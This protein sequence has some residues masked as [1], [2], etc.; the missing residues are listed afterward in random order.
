M[1]KGDRINLKD[2]AVAVING[3]GISDFIGDAYPIYYTVIK[4]GSEN[5]AGTAGV[6]SSNELR[7]A[8][9]EQSPAA[10]APYPS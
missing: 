4:D 8:S 9:N 7:K 2:G 3:N 10:Q 6:V 5:K 1:Q